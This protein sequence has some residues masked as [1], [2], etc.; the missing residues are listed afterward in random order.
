MLKNPVIYVEVGLQAILTGNFSPV[1]PSFTDRG[2]MSL[3]VERL[4]R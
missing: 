3:G 2:L 4:W 1:I